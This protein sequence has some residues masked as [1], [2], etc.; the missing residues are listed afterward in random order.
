M[1]QLNDDEIVGVFGTRPSPLSELILDGNDLANVVISR[2]SKDRKHMSGFAALLHACGGSPDMR[3]LSISENMLGDTGAKVIA[4]VLAHPHNRTSMTMLDLDK[5][6]I[7]DNGH[8]AIL[9]MLGCNLRLERVSLLNNMISEAWND[10][11]FLDMMSSGT[12]SQTSA[13]STSAASTSAASTSAASTF[14]STLPTTLHCEAML[15]LRMSDEGGAWNRRWVCSQHGT[16]FTSEERWI[17]WTRRNESE[18]LCKEAILALNEEERCRVESYDRLL[19]GVEEMQRPLLRPYVQY[20]LMTSA[21]QLKEAASFLQRHG[22]REGVHQFD[23]Q[24]GRNFDAAIGL[25][26]VQTSASTLTKLKDEMKKKA[27]VVSRKVYGEVNGESGG[28]G[29]DEDYKRYVGGCMPSFMQKEL[30]SEELN[31]GEK[32]S[33]PSGGLIMYVPSN[34]KEQE[35][36]EEEKEKEEKEEEKKVDKHADARTTRLWMNV[37]LHRSEREHQ[38]LASY[39]KNKSTNYSA[40]SQKDVIDNKYSINVLEMDAATLEG[41]MSGMEGM[42]KMGPSSYKGSSKRVVVRPL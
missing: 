28:N 18:T 2:G 32:Y 21:Q 9:R 36:K 39:R 41:K 17:K 25:T 8:L 40:T 4:H 30:V 27:S 6:D 33:L 37:N 22:G 29:G 3:R 15:G 31:N 10:Q 12:E 35:E 38:L 20:G 34:L 7:S 16:R 11:Q 14:S 26:T 1:Q 19:V 13:A 5:C 42:L 24:Q 23:L